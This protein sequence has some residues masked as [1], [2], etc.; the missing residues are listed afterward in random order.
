VAL[1]GREESR[2]NT[3]KVQSRVEE[4]QRPI[5]KSRGPV[6]ERHSR[7]RPRIRSHCHSYRK[8]SQMLR[9]RHSEVKP[10][11]RIGVEFVA[12][13]YPRPGAV[14]ECPDQRLGCGGDSANAG[15]M[16][17]TS[18]PHCPSTPILLA[19]FS[20]SSGHGSLVHYLLVP[21]RGLALFSTT[22][23]SIERTPSARAHPPL[24]ALALAV[25]E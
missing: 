5:P 24:Q 12:V 23:N 8:K 19:T 11:E 10:S 15:S 14:L 22:Q 20:R 16:R 2:I 4:L 7:R 13:E 18:S 1:R 21:R 3:D 6:Q 17:A 9:R 25:P